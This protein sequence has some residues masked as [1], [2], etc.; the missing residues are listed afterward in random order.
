MALETDSSNR[1]ETQMSRLRVTSRPIF[2]R[3][4]VF[5]P[6]RNRTRKLRRV[7]EERP[8]VRGHSFG[9]RYV[10]IFPRSLAT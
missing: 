4:P 1:S 2:P 10:L 3:I 8:R 6:R 9:K 5:D 7:V